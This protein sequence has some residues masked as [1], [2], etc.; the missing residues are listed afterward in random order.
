M[1]YFIGVEVLNERLHP[2]DNSLFMCTIIKVFQKILTVHFSLYI[3]VSL[4]KTQRNEEKL[5]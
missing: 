5:G 1:F 3:S 4:T 2:L